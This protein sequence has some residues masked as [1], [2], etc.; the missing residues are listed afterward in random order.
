MLQAPMLTMADNDLAAA[1]SAAGQPGHSGGLLART[2]ECGAGLTSLHQE[3][4]AVL[5]RVRAEE[6]DLTN[7]GHQPDSLEDRIG[8]VTDQLQLLEVGVAESG[9]MLHLADHFDSME[10]DR[11]LAKMELTRV[12]V[13]QRRMTDVDRVC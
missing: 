2:R 4:L 1:A 6:D 8:A 7:R 11:G 9:L 10:A 5:A 3:H 12:K 13:G